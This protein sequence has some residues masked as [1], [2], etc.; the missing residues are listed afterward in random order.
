MTTMNPRKRRRVLDGWDQR[1]SQ[2]T[3]APLIILNDKLDQLIGNSLFIRPL[4]AKLDEL[5][6]LTTKSNNRVEEQIRRVEEQIRRNQYAI[7]KLEKQINDLQIHALHGQL[8]SC[9]D[10]QAMMN[11]Y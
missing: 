9:D 6:K 8:Q 7:D 4:F 2:S 10:D 5:I 1:Q 11:M 3:D